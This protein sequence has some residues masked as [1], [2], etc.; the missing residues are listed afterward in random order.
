M[1]VYERSFHRWLFSVS[2]AALGATAT[3]QLS[4]VMKTMANTGR[5]ESGS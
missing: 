4:P 2:L 1:Q 3:E 5:D